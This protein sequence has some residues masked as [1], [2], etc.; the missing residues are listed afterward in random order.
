MF[1]RREA[2]LAQ[3]RE[4]SVP[5]RIG[6]RTGS[7]PPPRASRSRGGADDPRFVF[8]VP[9]HVAVLPADL[10]NAAM[11]P[12]AAATTSSAMRRSRARWSSSLS[13]SKSRRIARSSGPAPRSR[14]AHRG[15]MKTLAARG[16]LWGKVVGQ[17]LRRTRAIRRSALTSLPVAWAGVGRRRRS[18]SRIAS[19]APEALV[20]GARPGPKPSIV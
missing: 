19:I 3:G 6:V 15:W 2:H 16:A 20:P 9:T 4:P 17:T 1:R 18:R 14:S 12:G 8:E 13:S 5:P 11:R 10:E 7:T